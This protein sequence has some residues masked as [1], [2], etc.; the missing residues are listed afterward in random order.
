MAVR[1]T[2]AGLR[3]STA[4]RARLNAVTTAGELVPGELIWVTDEARLVQAIS[5]TAWREV[6]HTGQIPSVPEW[7]AEED[8]IAGTAT[9]KLMNPLRVAQAVAANMPV[10]GV[11]FEEFTTSGTFTKDPRDLFY[12]VHLISGGQGGGAHGSAMVAGGAGGNSSFGDVF[13]NYST[14]TSGSTSDIL[15]GKNDQAMPGL[16]AASGSGVSSSNVAG[17][18]TAG[19][20]SFLGST[21]GG[22]AAT[23]GGTGTGQNGSFPGGG[24]GAGKLYASGSQAPAGGIGGRGMFEV[25][26]PFMVASTVSVVVGAGGVGGTSYG[27]RGGDGAPGV[28]RVWRMRG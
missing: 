5:A 27:A 7:A 4:T 26:Y 17:G 15:F 3:P 25:L 21:G 22:G 1:N 8:A 28:V 9:D 23:V 18:P 14:I 6:A 2:G 12:I 13:V 11:I 16:R 20:S 24:G 19:L 10:A